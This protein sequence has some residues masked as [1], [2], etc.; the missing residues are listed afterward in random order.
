MRG[1]PFGDYLAALANSESMVPDEGDR[2][3]LRDAA[4]VIRQRL[5]ESIREPLVLILHGPDADPLAAAV[6]D[7][8]NAV[9]E[10]ADQ[11]QTFDDRLAELRRLLRQTAGDL[12]H[13]YS[14][15]VTTKE[16]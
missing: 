1:T 9:G 3:L 11:V 14:N 12:D 2:L 16:G 8:Q 6:D 7:M 13:T 10:I 4:E 5:A 15:L